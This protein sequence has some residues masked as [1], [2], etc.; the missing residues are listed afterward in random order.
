MRKLYEVH[1]EVAWTLR[2]TVQLTARDAEEAAGRARK[3]APSDCCAATKME[4]RVL[5]I[6]PKNSLT[7]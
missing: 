1:L 6:I 4:V 7:L 3:G 5:R 2:A